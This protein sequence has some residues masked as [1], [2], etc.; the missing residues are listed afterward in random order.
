MTSIEL[1]PTYVAY[2]YIDLVIF[3]GFKTVFWVR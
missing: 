2:F 3:R 1:I